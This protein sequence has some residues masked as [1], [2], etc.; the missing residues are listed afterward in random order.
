MVGYGPGSGKKEHLR[1]EYR[2]PFSEAQPP[3]LHMH[4]H[5]FCNSLM[6]ETQVEKSKRKNQGILPML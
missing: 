1:P 4:S 6:A 2:L 3:P 5:I